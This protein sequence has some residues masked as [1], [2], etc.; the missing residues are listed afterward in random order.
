MMFAL[1]KRLR[2]D[3]RGA[4][5]VEFALLLPLIMVVSMGLLD[6][7]HRFFSKA[8]FEGAVQKA[9]RD[10][11]LESG[12]S[13]A[14]NTLIDK[15]VKDNFKEVNGSVTD[16]NFTF[17]RR[18]FKD[19]TN[20]GK[21]EPSTGPGGQC[22]PP[23]GGTTYT[24]VDINNS[25]TWDDGAQ[26]GQGGANDVVLYTA[27]VTY[28]SLFPV[29]SLFGASQY[30]TIKASTVLRNQPYNSQATRTTGPTRNC[31]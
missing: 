2:A 19:F 21:M 6:F 26:G 18:N 13:V 15:K 27:T 11:T 5:L 3:K 28:R 20:S 10:A 30:Q 12:A 9:A 16:S 1:I 29:N 25:N 31:T 8:M 22:A 4:T 24:Y 17:T 23:S 7:A 14:S